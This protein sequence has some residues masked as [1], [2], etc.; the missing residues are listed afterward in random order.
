MSSLQM[1]RA[2]SE[3]RFLM[4]LSAPRREWSPIAKASTLARPRTA[5]G[6]AGRLVARGRSP[7]GSP[8]GGGGSCT[9][10]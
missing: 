1:S 4:R 8:E 2:T 5:G 7:K 9:K 3:C 10:M 6:Q